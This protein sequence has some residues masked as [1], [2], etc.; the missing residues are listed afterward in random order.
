MSS[1]NTLE[2]NDPLESTSLN[3]DPNSKSYSTKSYSKDK[4]F[5]NCDLTWLGHHK[6]LVTML[7]A[8][9]AV[10]VC[11]PTYF[12]IQ[13]TH[14]LQINCYPGPVE[15]RYVGLQEP[16]PIFGDYKCAPGYENVQ[17]YTSKTTRDIPGNYRNDIE[18][19][20]YHQNFCCVQTILSYS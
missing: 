8:I 10:I 7:V 5:S 11:I 16:C 6:C 3:F 20:C 14:Q 18:T 13:M 17:N 2:S 15:S 9:L 12:V 1:R 4:I 19:I